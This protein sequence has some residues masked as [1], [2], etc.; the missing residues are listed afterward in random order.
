VGLARAAGHAVGAA[1]LCAGR[2]AVALGPVPG[3]VLRADDVRAPRRRGTRH[4][5]GPR[6]HEPGVAGRPDGDRGDPRHRPSEPAVRAAREALRRRRSDLPTAS[7]AAQGCRRG[8]DQVHRRTVVAD[9]DRRLDARRA[10]VTRRVHRRRVGSARSAR[11]HGR[12]ARQL[13]AA[14][15]A[16]RAR[17]PGRDRRRA[18]RVAQRA[19]LVRDQPIQR[20]AG[21]RPPAADRPGEGR[22]AASAD[23][24]RHRD[25]G[26]DAPPRTGR[27][28]ADCPHQRARHTAGAGRPRRVH[29]PN[30]VP[31]Q[32]EPAAR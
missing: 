6:R 25:Q 26:R 27:R 9:R 32:D 31:T 19:D 28:R 3:G 30:L 4:P 18:D 12:R 24:D 15:A 16:A 10:A 2:R 8:R 5:R 21:L 23:R 11:E 13:R 22:R 7:P 29:D 17:T 1:C 20:P 14:S